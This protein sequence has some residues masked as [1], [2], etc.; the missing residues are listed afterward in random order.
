MS[1]ERIERTFKIKFEGCPI[2]AIVIRVNGQDA[3]NWAISEAQRAV[4]SLNPSYQCATVS[5]CTYAEIYY[6]S[7]FGKDEKRGQ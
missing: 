6:G 2:A 4:Q 7:V 5:E 1:E 3:R